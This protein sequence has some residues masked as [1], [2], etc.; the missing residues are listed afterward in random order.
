MVWGRKANLFPEH[1]LCTE[2]YISQDGTSQLFSH[3]GIQK[4]IMKFVTTHR[5]KRMRLPLSR[6]DC[7]ETLAIPDRAQPSFRL[8]ALTSPKAHLFSGHEWD[9]QPYYKSL[10]C[11]LS[12]KILQSSLYGIPE[13]MINILGDSEPRRLRKSPWHP[14]CIGKPS[15]LQEVVLVWGS[16]IREVQQC[17]W[18]GKVP[19]AR[20]NKIENQKKGQL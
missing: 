19:W 13:L 1:F 10:Q 17:W 12:L 15:L 3:H 14:E 6:K 2:H 11:G 7:Q 18:Q 16:V 4:K 9:P 20:E 5:G 8:S